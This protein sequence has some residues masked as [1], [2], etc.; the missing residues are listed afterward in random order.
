MDI[1]D[2]IREIPNIHHFTQSLIRFIGRSLLNDKGMSEAIERTYIESCSD[3]E[4]KGTM[5]IDK[6]S[7]WCPVTSGGFQMCVH[8]ILCLAKIDGLVDNILCGMHAVGIL[9]SLIILE[10]ENQVREKNAKSLRLLYSVHLF[11]IF[12]VGIPNSA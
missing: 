9:L 5:N 8:G 2:A 12:W 10:P 11:F 7:V 3:N 1:R 4:D 6:E